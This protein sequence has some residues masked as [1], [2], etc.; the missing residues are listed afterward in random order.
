[1]MINFPADILDRMAQNSP[2]HVL[3][4][5]TAAAFAQARNRMSTDTGRRLLDAM[6]YMTDT[7]LEIMC[8]ALRA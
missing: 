6:P 8:D 2:L 3:D 4:D 5:E 1:M 7:Q